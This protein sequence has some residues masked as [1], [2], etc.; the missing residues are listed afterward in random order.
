MNKELK[1][2][3]FDVP[4]HILNKISKTVMNLNGQYAHGKDRAEELL[5]KR[6]V[7]YGQLKRI[8]HDFQNVDKLKDKLRFELYGGQEM[9]NW[10]RQH[11]Q[12]ERD[13]ISNRKDSEMRADNISGVGGKNT[14][15]KKHSKKPDWLPPTNLVKSNSHKNSITSLKMGSLFEEVERIKKLML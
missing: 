5:Q 4:E 8:I 12:G 15:L 14:H 9:E 1:D 2:R 11:L 6:K 7:K 10:A 13:L 3:V